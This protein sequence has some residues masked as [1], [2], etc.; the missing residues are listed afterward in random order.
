VVGQQCRHD[1]WIPIPGVRWWWLTQDQFEREQQRLPGQKDSGRPAVVVVKR[2]S[3]M[4]RETRLD[5]A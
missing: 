1:E 5:A 2:R 4:P 3:K